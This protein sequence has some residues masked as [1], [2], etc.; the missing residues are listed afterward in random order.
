MS[1]KNPKIFGLDVNQ[2]FA[3]VLDADVA[4]SLIHI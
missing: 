4:L 3:D 2:Y 1:I